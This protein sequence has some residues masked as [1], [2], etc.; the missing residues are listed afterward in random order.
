[1]VCI[2]SSLI[3]VRVF[4]SKKRKEKNFGRYCYGVGEHQPF[5]DKMTTIF[6][7]DLDAC[8]S[9]IQK[10]NILHDTISSLL[11]IYIYIYIYIFIYKG[12]MLAKM[13]IYSFCP[14]QIEKYSCFESR[15]LKKSSFNKKTRFNEN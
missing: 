2:P 3:S 14:K 15:V 5:I 4:Q 9:I 10:M 12:Y 13:G 1:M 11:F 7:Q 6:M 8:F